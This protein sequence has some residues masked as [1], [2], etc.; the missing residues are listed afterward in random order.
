LPSG[1]TIAECGTGTAISVKELAHTIHRLTRSTSRL[2]F[3]ALP[4]RVGEVSR[5]VADP[6]ILRR[7]GWHPEV[8]LEEGL[9]ATIEPNHTGAHR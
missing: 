7:L 5:S 3:G 1:L 6:T 8:G 2:N 9:K 4:D